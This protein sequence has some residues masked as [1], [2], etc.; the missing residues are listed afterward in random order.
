MAALPGTGAV[1]SLEIG[2][3]KPE[4]VVSVLHPVSWPVGKKVTLWGNY[5]LEATSVTLNGLPATSVAVTSVR[6]VVATV[7][8]GATTGPVSINTTAIGPFSTTQ[9]FTVQ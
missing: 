5:L 9:R 1:L 8:A 4:P 6:S 2:L 3:P 7:P